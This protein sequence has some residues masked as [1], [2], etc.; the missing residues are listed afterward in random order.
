MGKS[1]N[2]LPMTTKARTQ[3]QVSNRSGRKFLIPPF[4]GIYA[5]RLHSRTPFPLVSACLSFKERTP[6]E[7]LQT[8]KFIQ[9]MLTSTKRW[10][11]CKALPKWITLFIL[12]I[13]SGC[14]GCQTKNSKNIPSQKNLIREATKQARELPVNLQVL[15]SKLVSEEYMTRHKAWQQLTQR[16]SPPKKLLYP[17]AQFILSSQ[18]HERE[19]ALKVITLYNNVNELFPFFDH[20][21]NHIHKNEEDILR[22]SLHILLTTTSGKKRY[23]L[24]LLRNPKHFIRKATIEYISKHPNNFSTK[25]ISFIHKIE[26]NEQNTNLRTES[27]SAVLALS[28]KNKALFVKQALYYINDK[29]LQIQKNVLHFIRTSKWKSSQIA[30]ILRK[31]I[32]ESP[33]HTLFWGLLFEALNRV[34][35]SGQVDIQTLKKGLLGKSAPSVATYIYSRIPQQL[36]LFKKEFLLSTERNYL[37]LTT[38]TTFKI[39]QALK[40]PP[41]VLYLT[42]VKKLQ[43]KYVER[44]KEALLFIKR[45]NTFNQRTLRHV[46]DFF[47]KSPDRDNSLLALNILLKAS[48]TTSKQCD[49]LSLGMMHQN[50][51]IV[52]ASV[53]KLI[54]AKQVCTNIYSSALKAYRRGFLSNKGIVAVIEKLGPEEQVKHLTSI[55]S[56]TSHLLRC[57]NIFIKTLLSLAGIIKSKKNYI[58]HALTHPRSKGMNALALLYISTNRTISPKVLN[59][60]LLF[61]EK[62]DFRICKCR[63]SHRCFL[64]RVPLAL[65]AIASKKKI[66][67][68]QFFKKVFEA[69]SKSPHKLSRASLF[70]NAFKAQSF[71]KAIKLSVLLSYLKRVKRPRIKNLLIRTMTHIAPQ[72]EQVVSYLV[73]SLVK[74]KGK[75]LFFI[76]KALRHSG[77]IVIPKLTDMFDGKMPLSDLDLS[78][79]GVLVAYGLKNT[80]IIEKWVRMAALDSSTT[81]FIAAS[82]LKSPHQKKIISHLLLSKK[83]NVVIGALLILKHFP[84]TQQRSF[85]YQLCSL[86][87]IQSRSI[88]HLL[89]KILKEHAC[90]K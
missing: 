27:S 33:K 57:D 31:K 24:H 89:Q 29:D 34:S 10:S 60:L 23:T 79:G 76:I 63:T 6:F 70:L 17:I 16:K 58:S 47:I 2:P 25:L 41:K 30:N 43:S 20:L 62:D 73:Q 45:S 67:Q 7:W 32:R 90:K 72:N 82:L 48:N 35:S 12:G 22:Q 37:S 69:I 68:I 84:R 26:R 74:S 81:P 54:S 49:V 21:F 61:A 39:L 85:T 86:F 13:A 52:T 55:L 8:R 11:Q 88:H 77:E 80:Q 64:W 83:T 51:Y 14:I 5:I 66:L 1:M 75:Q 3:K 15:L 42:T 56:H 65:K 46:R 38:E 9:K 44:R 18:Y 87:N 50:F 4:S 28:K 40:I 53:R 36:A 71:S 59:T 19:A 78:I